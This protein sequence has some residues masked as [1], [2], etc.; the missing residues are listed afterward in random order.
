V[1][2]TAPPAATH[3]RAAHPLNPPR[4]QIG[5]GRFS[6][7]GFVGYEADDTRSPSMWVNDGDGSGLYWDTRTTGT[8]TDAVVDTARFQCVEASLPVHRPSTRARAHA[9]SWPCWSQYSGTAT[10]V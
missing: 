5:G 8:E 10:P 2:S 3:R 1:I 6:W 4:R 7:H 9:A